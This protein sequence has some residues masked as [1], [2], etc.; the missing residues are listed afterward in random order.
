MANLNRNYS[1]HIK[2]DVESATP[3]VELRTMLGVT[4]RDSLRAYLIKWREARR[5]SEGGKGAGDSRKVDMVSLISFLVGLG[6]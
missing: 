4:A 6:R 5:G 3:T 2:P 1:P